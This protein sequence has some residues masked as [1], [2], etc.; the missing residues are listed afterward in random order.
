MELPDDLVSQLTDDAFHTQ[1]ES[2]YLTCSRVSF[3]ES[4]NNPVSSV[5]T[6]LDDPDDIDL[7]MLVEMERIEASQQRTQVRID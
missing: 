2:G 5:P 7:S 1:E 6:P 4:N 3:S